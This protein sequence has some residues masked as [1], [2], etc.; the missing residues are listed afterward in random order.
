M[1]AAAAPHSAGER[2]PSPPG[3]ERPGP[4]SASED[5]VLLRPGGTLG[6]P[7]G[8]HLARRNRTCTAAHLPQCGAGWG[9]EGASSLG[10]CPES[11]WQQ[12]LRTGSSAQQPREAGV[13]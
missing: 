12:L 13:S 11:S 9:D 4:R 6:L 2:G 3:P 8:A 1:R 7:G 10:P 5:P